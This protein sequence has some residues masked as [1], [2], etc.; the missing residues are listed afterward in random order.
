MRKYLK[1]SQEENKSSL[2]SD[3]EKSLFENFFGKEV[4]FSKQELKQI[5]RSIV[6]VSEK[7]NFSP[8]PLPELLQRYELNKPG[9]SD[10]IIGY[11]DKNMEHRIKVDEHKMYIEKQS[12]EQEIR[13]LDNQNSRVKR[14][15]WFAF[16]IA[17]TGASGAIVC[18]FLGLQVLGAALV[19]FPIASIISNFLVSR[20]SKDEKA[21]KNDQFLKGGLSDG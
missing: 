12:I 14:S 9:F 20:E 21:E 16:I 19:G 2:V 13:F 5:E 17:M 1:P 7:K 3:K 15:Q 10:K 18:A 6:Q 8:Y 11:I 4:D